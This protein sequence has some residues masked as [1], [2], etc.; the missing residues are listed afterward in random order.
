VGYISPLPRVSHRDRAVP[1]PSRINRVG[2]QVL[3]A[4]SR[5]RMVLTKTLSMQ[6][7]RSLFNKSSNSGWKDEESERIDRSPVA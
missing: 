4:S 3:K 6:R 2:G 1:D 5:L 7:S